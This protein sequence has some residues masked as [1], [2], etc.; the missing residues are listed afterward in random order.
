MKKGFLL[1]FSKASQV[2]GETLARVWE[3]SSQ[4]IFN[5]YSEAMFMSINSLKKQIK[6]I[7][8][9]DPAIKSTVEVFLYPS[10]WAIVSHKIAHKLYRSKHY[11]AARLISQLSRG[12]TGI[13]IHPGA[14]VGD[15]V[16]IDHGTGVVIGETCVIGNNVTIYQGVTL[17]GTGKDVGKRHP[18]VEDNVL[19]GSGAKVLGPIVIGKGSKIGAGSVVLSDVAPYC[20]VVGVPGRAVRRRRIYSNSPSDDLDQIHIPDPVEMEICNLR[21]RVEYLEKKLSQKEAAKK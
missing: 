18:T 16:F 15:G 14:E 1:L 8:K 19:I 20:T 5:L 17:G 9:K 21:N 12:L 6:T 10:F 2:K 13:E 4:E 11:F 7:K 3:R